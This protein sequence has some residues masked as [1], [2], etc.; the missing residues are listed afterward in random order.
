MRERRLQ[1]LRS[2][3]AA[4]LERAIA[5]AHRPPK[6][7]FSCIVPI[8][9]EEV[10]MAEP[11]LLALVRRLRDGLPVW[12]AGVVHIRAVLVDGTSPLYLDA[13]PGAL[14]AWARVTL[15]ELDD[16]LD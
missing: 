14:R 2:T 12:P 5:N 3:T 1:R 15:A 13:R 9:R 6:A 10:L 7:T 11:F 8:C 4:G 16:G